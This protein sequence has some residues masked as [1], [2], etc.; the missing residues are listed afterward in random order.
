[1]EYCDCRIDAHCMGEIRQ[2][3]EAA[4]VLM[5]SHPTVL[6]RSVRQMQRCSCYFATHCIERLCA[7]SED[8]STDLRTARTNRKRAA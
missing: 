4:L 3:Q 8:L 1:M 5:S 6:L 7:L 2:L